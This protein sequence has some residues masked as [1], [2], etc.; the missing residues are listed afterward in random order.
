MNHHN[1]VNRNYNLLFNNLLKIPMAFLLKRHHV[2]IYK[3]NN[4]KI[5]GKL[6]KI[7]NIKDKE[8]ITYLVLIYKNINKFVY[9]Y[10]HN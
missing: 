6:S 1:I 3:N 7:K 5:Q 8:M 9:I 2:E 4:I 10:C